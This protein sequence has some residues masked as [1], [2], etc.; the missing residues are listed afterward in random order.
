MIVKGSDN[1]SEAVAQE[2]GLPEKKSTMSALVALNGK[3]LS[4]TKA[5][6]VG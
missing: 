5:S 6:S 4:L 1:R 2:A 3:P